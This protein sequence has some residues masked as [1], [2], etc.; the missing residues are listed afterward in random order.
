MR[1]AGTDKTV[2]DQWLVCSSRS[3]PHCACAVRGEC[4]LYLTS[5]ARQQLNAFLASPPPVTLNLQSTVY[6]F[7]TRGDIVMGAWHHCHHRHLSPRRRP[8][9]HVPHRSHPPPRSATGHGSAPRLG[10]GGAPCL[11]PRGHPPVGASRDPHPHPGASLG[12]P[13]PQRPQRPRHRPPAP[14]LLPVRGAGQDMTHST[15]P[16]QSAHLLDH[17]VAIHSPC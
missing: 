6:A 17:Y 8:P 2:R 9:V 16:Y 1:T 13:R 7:D 12:P 15:C 10:Q 11:C 3:T 14:Q 5:G 4:Q